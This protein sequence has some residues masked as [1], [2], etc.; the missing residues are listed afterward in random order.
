MDENQK[1]YYKFGFSE[2]RLKTF[3]E[4]KMG[5]QELL[6]NKKSLT[7]EEI[8]SFMLSYLIIESRVNE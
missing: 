2:G 7:K 5:L 4:L 6:R 1:K 8:N 3:T